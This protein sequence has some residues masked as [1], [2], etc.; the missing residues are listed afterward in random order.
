MKTPILVSAAAA[1]LSIPVAVRRVPASPRPRGQ[2]VFSGVWTA[3][4]PTGEVASLGEVCVSRVVSAGAHLVLGQSCVLRG[5]MSA[6]V[7][8]PCLNEAVCFLLLSCKIFHVFWN[9]MIGKHFISFCWLPFLFVDSAFRCTHF[10]NTHE[11]QFVCFFFCWLCLEL[12]PRKCHHVQWRG[13][14]APCFLLRAFTFKSVIY[15]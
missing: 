9:S 1:P 3:A 2:W 6:P 12:Q 10:K 13:A 8:G 15:S 14:F 4:A 7:L 11:V 5:A